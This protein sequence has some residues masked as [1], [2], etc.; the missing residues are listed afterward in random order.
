MS[1]N[2]VPLLLNSNILLVLYNICLNLIIK[3]IIICAIHNNH[4][5]LIPSRIEILTTYSPSVPTPT[6]VFILERGSFST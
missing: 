4:S 5:R 3:Y 6:Q 2:L 1:E